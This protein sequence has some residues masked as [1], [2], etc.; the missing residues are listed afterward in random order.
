[1][2]NSEK[3]ITLDLLLNSL[4]DDFDKNERKHIFD[5]LKTND[6]AD[7]EALFGAKLLLEANN[8]DYKVLKKAFTK[9]EKRI[10]QITFSK[11]K[12]QKTYLKYA[13]VLI[14]IALFIGFLIGNNTKSI[15]SCYIK[16]EGLPNFMG[17]KKTNWDELMKL[18]RAKEMKKA[19]A[20]SEKILLNIKENDTAIY[21]HGVIAYE[22]NNYTT[23]K[24]DYSK[25]ILDP[26]SVFYHDA[27]YRLGFVLNHLQEIE[28]SKS[29]FRKVILDPNNP[30][31]KSAIEASEYLH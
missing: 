22:L 1:M 21:F 23:A 29:Q 24:K 28:A 2:T 27:T 12:S 9:T 15:D 11:T 16:E 17:D 3:K 4:N 25:I 13:A 7:D 31:K 5:I 8:W 6:F 18:Y 14:P 19:Y 26:K 10:D 30:Y 20:V